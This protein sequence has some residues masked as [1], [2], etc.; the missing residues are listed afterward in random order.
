MTSTITHAAQTGFANASSYDRHRPSYPLEAV[1]NLLK[2]LQIDGVTGARIV[3]LGAGTG[4]FTELLAKRRENYEILAIEPHEAMR[5]EL[6]RKKLKGV[7]VIAGDAANMPLESQTVDAVV[8]TQLNFGQIR[9]ANHDALKEIH[10][11]LQPSSVFA[12]I[13]NIEDYNGPESWHPTTIWESKIKAIT[14]RLDD[15]H[16]RFRHEQ[17]RQVF[18]EQLTTTPF[19]INAADPLFSLPLGEESVKF[20]YWLSKE[21]VWERYSTLSQIAVLEP[22]EKEVSSIPK[23][24]LANLAEYQYLTGG[25]PIVVPSAQ[26]SSTV[27]VFVAAN[28]MIESKERGIRCHGRKRC[29]NERDWRGSASRKHIFGLDIGYTWGAPEERRV[30]GHHQKCDTLDYSN[31][32]TV[33]LPLVKQSLA[34]SKTILSA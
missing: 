17:W 32:Q 30:I 27:L 5:Q 3:D 11:V 26:P 25:H 7:S 29:R 22:T 16:P 10:R 4:K 20:T 8:A 9:F 23:L 14:W 24:I 31:E 19:T 18:E 34:V 21:A 2:H 6:E 1:D 13:W 33:V 12:M 15:Q 28:K